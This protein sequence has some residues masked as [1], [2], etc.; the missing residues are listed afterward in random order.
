[1]MFNNIIISR[2]LIP[3]GL[4][5][6]VLLY[7]NHNYAVMARYNLHMLYC[8][9]FMKITYAV[10]IPKKDKERTVGFRVA[11]FER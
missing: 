9:K 7:T 3:H 11:Y 5:R 1:M 10:N 4:I 6:K 8:M 2:Q